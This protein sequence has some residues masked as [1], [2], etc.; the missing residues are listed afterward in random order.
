MFLGCLSEMCISFLSVSLKNIVIHSKYFAFF[1]GSNPP[2]ILHNGQLRLPYLEDMSKWI[3]FSSIWIIL[4]IIFSL[5]LY[6]LNNKLLKEYAM[7]C[8]E[9]I[10]SK[11]PLECNYHTD[12][13]S[14]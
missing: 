7:L 8:D 2:V 6:L 3:I 13:Q 12:N 11:E 1:I 4:H 9:R 5:I 14:S 10:S